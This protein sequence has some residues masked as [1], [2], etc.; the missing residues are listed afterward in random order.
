MMKKPAL[1]L[2][3][4][5]FFFAA[6]AQKPPAKFG[7]PQKFDFANNVCPV[8]SGADAYY[9][10]DYGNVRFVYD[11]HNGWK[12]NLERHLKIKIVNA[13]GKDY[14][15]IIIPYYEGRY[16]KENVYSPKGYTYNMENGK[17]LK[18]KL[19]KEHIF[20]EDLT[21]RRKRLKISMPNVKAG[22]IIE[23]TYTLVSDYWAYLR[24][25]EFQKD[26]PVL[27]SELNIGFPEYYKYNIN[28]KGYEV[29]AANN[30]ST[31]TGS[32]TILY[33]TGQQGN[34]PSLQSQSV[35]YTVYKRHMVAENM[36]AFKEEPYVT[37]MENYRSAIEF[38]LASIHYSGSKFQEFTTSWDYVAR[39][40]LQHDYFGLKLD[41]AGFARS[42]V[43]DIVAK[44][45]GQMNRMNAIYDMIRNRIKWDGSYGMYS[46]RGLRDVYNT[47]TGGAMDINFILINM[48]RAADIQAYPVVLSTRKNGMIFPTFP[49]VDKFNYVVALAVVDGKQ[50]FLDATDPY[51]PAGVLPPRCLNGK[52]R[53]I[54]DK[55]NIW[56]D[57]NPGTTASETTYYNIDMNEDGTFTGKISTMMKGYSAINFRKKRDEA[58]SLDKMIEDIKADHPGLE[59]TSYDIKGMDDNFANITS[60]LEVNINDKSDYLG[61]IISFNP[62]LYERMGENPLKLED[63]KFPVDFNYPFS[64]KDIVHI[65]LPKG[66]SVEA[67]P[68]KL[69]I[70]TPGKDAAF[71]YVVNS[72][73]NTI[74]LIVSFEVGKTVFLPSEYPIIKELFAQM[75]AK[76]AELV[77]IKKNNTQAEVI[78]Q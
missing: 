24:D 11:S 6:K 69:A 78:E 75:V 51:C 52:G 50:I 72:Q 17:I 44:N 74:D 37:T 26:I 36:P 25:W 38:E 33:K 45:P 14:A 59:V 70:T 22:S 20:K 65:N 46:Q 40:F 19:K 60:V 15:N 9:L 47:K 7:K 49:T 57:L 62:M 76:E 39:F 63:R 54:D 3:L 4:V 1:F 42:D 8:D 41:R 71:T 27:Y 56:V 32:A 66:Y 73:A 61:D 2:V 53:I 55:V 16:N 34:G 29:L 77:T 31:E 12:W 43:K 67:L 48:L 64:K 18:T 21:E 13:N 35:M 30:S 58:K 68:E 23:V 5:M 28:M 10:F